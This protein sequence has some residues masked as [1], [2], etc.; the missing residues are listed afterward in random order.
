MCHPCSHRDNSCTCFFLPFCHFSG[1]FSGASWERHIVSLPLTHCM[2]L[3]K[4]LHPVITPFLVCSRLLCNTQQR[5]RGGG[6]HSGEREGMS[7][8]VNKLMVNTLRVQLEYTLVLF[9]PIM[10]HNL[11][12]ER[13][14]VPQQQLKS[15]GESMDRVETEIF[16]VIKAEWVSFLL[17]TLLQSCRCCSAPVHV[18][19]GSKGC[20]CRSKVLW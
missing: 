13:C 4:L 19:D 10:V 11:S 9:V 6:K 20:A 15:S 2:S 17:M 1:L 5:S 16:L 7:G 14:I 3:G 8:K 12:Q 18:T